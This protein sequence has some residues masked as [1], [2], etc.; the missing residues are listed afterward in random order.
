MIIAKST[1]SGIYNSVGYAVTDKID[2]AFGFT[3][4][5]VPF[6]VTARRPGDVAVL[7]ACSDR[8]RADMGWEP[9]Y[10]DLEAIITTAWEWHSSHP[11]GYT[12]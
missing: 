12:D 9:S 7:T 10:P 5:R 1:L 4:K 11:N 6:K 3:G 8:I 2:L